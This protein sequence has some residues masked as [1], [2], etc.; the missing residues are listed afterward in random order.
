[1]HHGPR[2]AIDFG[3]TRTKVAY[4]DPDREEA[5]L[6]E[7]GIAQREIIPS[8]FY[9]PKL[10]CGKILVG[11][12][13]MAQLDVD[14]AG[15]VRE[16][17]REIDKL[18]KKRCGA[19]RLAP[20]RV[21]LAAELLRTVRQRCEEGIF[22]GQ[23]INKCTL[24]VP[25][26]FT[27]SQRSKLLE[28]ANQAGFNDVRLMDEP[29][30][31]ARAWVEKQ[32]ERFGE[33]V[34]VVDIG[35]GT[36]DF[37]VVEWS[38]NRFAPHSTVL[39]VGFAQGGNDI[40]DHAC[41]EIL[42][43]QEEE[44]EESVLRIKDSFLVRLRSIK[45]Q[46]TRGLKRQSISAGS[47]KIEIQPTAFRA[48]ETDF[49]N[50]LCDELQSF[51][52]KCQQNGIKS[53]S[54]LL[55]GGA[56]RITGLVEKLRGICPHDVFTWETADFATVLGAV[57]Y[58][59]NA[60]GFE[61]V[62]QRKAKASYVEALQAANADGKITDAEIDYLTARRTHLG[63]SVKEFEKLEVEILGRCL[64]QIDPAADVAQTV[65]LANQALLAEVEFEIDEGRYDMALDQLQ[66]AL[67][68]TPNVPQYLVL[69]ARANYLRER[70]DL[71]ISAATATLKISQA[72]QEARFILGMSL[73][74]LDRLDDAKEN[75]DNLNSELSFDSEIEFYLAAIDYRQGRLSDISLRLEKVKRPNGALSRAILLIQAIVALTEQDGP[76]VV[77]KI[78]EFVLKCRG[79]D[80]ETFSSVVEELKLFFGGAYSAVAN[81]FI[82]GSNHQMV[83]TLAYWLFEAHRMT[84]SSDDKLARAYVRSCV[85]T[86]ISIRTVEQFNTE[87]IIVPALSEA[88]LLSKTCHIP[89]ADLLAL[90]MLL[91]DNHAIDTVKLR[92]EKNIRKIGTL[93]D[94]LRPKVVAEESHTYLSNYVRVVNQSS[95]TITAVL[96]I[97]IVTRS[98]DSL[99]TVQLHVRELASGMSYQWNPV[100]T[101]PG[102]LGGQI[103]N[104]SI[105]ITCDQS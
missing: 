70:Y 18:G 9:V 22:H 61:T 48:A 20:T 63:L 15:I 97:V 55:V 27:E 50:R 37:S 13:A 17:K 101:N 36:T 88:A 73:F 5:R 45:E 105:E 84:A 8:V 46:F 92:N 75:L 7:L 25:V 100:F 40:D 74:F 60:I 31:A 12:D 43:Q 54:V 42:S 35:G 64:S 19:G 95:F 81:K 39:P 85:R 103:K 99:E 67:D 83:D 65:V 87:E 51:F 34:V 62:K 11:D 68:E 102:L 66:M 57:D 72:D 3:T 29:T 32:G 23:I 24:T 77:A 1:M 104:V 30:A 26:S 28:A 94:R 93:V 80:D 49:V 56:S 59:G 14:P 90:L 53:P 58:P 86:G 52:E 38:N 4:Y 16:I 76:T 10:G 6:I 47:V 33:H 2:L 69:K 71:A 82:R 98:D 79:D 41:D 78:E 96:V 91:I 44:D 21:E 89:K